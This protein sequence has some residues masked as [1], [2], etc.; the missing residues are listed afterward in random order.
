[1][2][3]ASFVVD[4]LLVRHVV[5]HHGQTRRNVVQFNPARGRA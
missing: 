3:P 5:E 4:D 1:V 2:K